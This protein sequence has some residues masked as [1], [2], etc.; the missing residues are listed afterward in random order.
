MISRDRLPQRPAYSQAKRTP[1]HKPSFDGGDELHERLFVPREYPIDHSSFRGLG[2]TLVDSGGQAFFETIFC[3]RLP[4]HSVAGSCFTVRSRPSADSLRGKR[5]FASMQRFLYVR[6]CPLTLINMPG[7]GEVRI[8]ILES[9]SS[10][11]EM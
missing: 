4:Q 1:S 8:S 9:A 6:G 5:V 3:S 11:A 10:Y 2:R 7:G